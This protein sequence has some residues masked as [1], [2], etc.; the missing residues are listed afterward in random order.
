MNYLKI[1][2]MSLSFVVAT[3]LASHFN[4][5]YAV[6]AGIVA[7][8]SIQDTKKE[9]LKIGADR[10]L[11]FTLALVL[12]N[13]VFR[14]F[15][16]YIYSFG[17]F[18]LFFVGFSMKFNIEN[19]ISMNAVIATH[20]LL[21]KSISPEIMINELAIFSIGAITG[22]VLNLYM[23]L[24]DKSIKQ[25]QI[26]IEQSFK[27]ILTSMSSCILNNNKTG[28]LYTTIND[29][30]KHMEKVR[31]LA[32]ETINNRLLDD[33]K[34]QLTYLDM[35]IHQLEHLL[36]IYD[37]MML[38]DFIP[39]ESKAIAK[40]FNDIALSFH[41]YNEASEQLKDLALLKENYKKSDLPVTRI[42]FENRSHLI[43]ILYLLEEFL[44]LKYEFVSS[45]S[46][47]EKQKYWKDSVS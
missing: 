10:F 38:M 6:S 5:N 40:I 28:I 31:Q 16:F 22:I 4:L 34:Y 19:G 46:Y 35:R 15:D 7:L 42:E 41:E 43:Q 29:L 12:A 36:H 9:T 23:P 45:L 1:I 39:E 18:L 11:S 27:N 14:L 37:Q 3:S 47:R 8:L 30:S 13:L 33:T 24:H 25:E 2:K 32:Y 26:Y 17:I 20:Y 21:E 44:V